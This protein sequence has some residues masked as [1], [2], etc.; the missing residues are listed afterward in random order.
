[1][2]GLLSACASHTGIVSTGPDT[3]LL[4]KQ[5]ATGFPGLGNLKA[6]IIAEG[7]AHCRTAGKEFMLVRSSESAPPYVMG[8]YPR[9]EIEFQCLRAGD[10]GLQ[11]PR[12]EPVPNTVIQVR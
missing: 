10:P 11:R 8:N 2:C 6:E 12:M 4:A 9:A 1:M 5:A 3:Y 7:S